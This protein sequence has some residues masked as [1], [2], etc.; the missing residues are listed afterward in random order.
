MRRRGGAAKVAGTEK[1]Q[2]E[3]ENKLKK[4]YDRAEKAKGKKTG[5]YID[6]S[7]VFTQDQMDYRVGYID[8]QNAIGK[9]KSFSPGGRTSFPFA[10]PIADLWREHSSSCGRDGK[11]TVRDWLTN[12]EPLEAVTA[13]IQGSFDV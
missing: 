9:L 13:A 12:V 4:V 1:E 7:R 6:P 10:T 2:R 5:A 8:V 3:I 11:M